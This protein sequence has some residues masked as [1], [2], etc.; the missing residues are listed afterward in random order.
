MWSCLDLDKCLAILNIISHR[1]LCH[2]GLGH[3]HHCHP[4]CLSLWAHSSVS[5]SNRRFGKEANRENPVWRGDQIL[6]F[7]ITKSFQLLVLHFQFVISDSTWVLFSFYFL[8]GSLP[9][10]SSYFSIRSS[11]SSI[12]DD[13]FNSA[14]RPA[15]S[16][17][18]PMYVIIT[19]ISSLGSAFTKHLTSSNPGMLEATLTEMGPC[20][21]NHFKWGVGCSSVIGERIASKS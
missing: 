4:F 6:S 18:K 20:F 14:L 8:L 2:S 10:F 1:V 7:L 5:V 3:C 11:K 12:L 16:T 15:K 13:H 9:D 21:R 17:M 19:S